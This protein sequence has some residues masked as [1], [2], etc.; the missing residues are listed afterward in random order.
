MPTPA[1]SGS[2]SARSVSASEPSRS[3][4]HSARRANFRWHCRA[5]ASRDGVNHPATGTPQLRSYPCPSNRGRRKPDLRLLHCREAHGSSI[6]Q[7]HLPFVEV[8]RAKDRIQ[9][10]ACPLKATGSAGDRQA[11]E[12]VDEILAIDVRQQCQ[13]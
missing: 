3:P 6:A 13:I 2:T 8:D 11:L 9:I 12:I 1:I 5:R 10:S 4:S 7:G